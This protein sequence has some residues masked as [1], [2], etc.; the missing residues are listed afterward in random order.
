MED[1][2]RKGTVVAA[3]PTMADFPAPALARLADEKEPARE[4]QKAGQ[5][6]CRTW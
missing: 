5:R 2:Q 3:A 1:Y 6:C 4:P